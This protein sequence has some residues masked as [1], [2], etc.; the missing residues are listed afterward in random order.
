MC[1]LCGMWAHRCK[2]RRS[3]K[4]LNPTE[5]RNRSQLHHVVTPNAD[6][7]Q[8]LGAH[9]STE[10]AVQEDALAP[11]GIEFTLPRFAGEQ[12]T[13]SLPF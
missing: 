4:P 9:A 1:V 10:E 7:S 5:N 3:E 2:A 8:Y 6:P 11:H 12:I 13:Q